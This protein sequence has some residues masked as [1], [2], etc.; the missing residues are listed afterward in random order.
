MPDQES[1]KTKEAAVLTQPP[2]FSSVFPKSA[3]PV[4]NC[5]LIVRE[6]LYFVISLRGHH[7]MIV[8]VRK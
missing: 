5:V 2:L 3:K 4:Q 7:Y 1:T 8:D 6:N